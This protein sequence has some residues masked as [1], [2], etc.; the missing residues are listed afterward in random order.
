MSYKG[1][2]E[3]QKLRED[4]NHVWGQGW[5]TSA[6]Y[7][8]PYDAIWGKAGAL[9][10]DGWDFDITRE[11]QYARLTA[12]RQAQPTTPGTDYYDRFS[13]S[14]E[15]IEKDIW[16]LD[17]LFS[18]VNAKYY[19][20]LEAMKDTVMS[21][22]EEGNLKWFEGLSESEWPETWGVYREIAA[23]VEAYEEE[24]KVLTRE[25]VVSTLYN[26]KLPLAKY[27]VSNIYSTEALVRDFYLPNPIPGIQWPTA[28]EVNIPNTA[29]G[30]RNRDR[31]VSQQEGQKVLL[32][33]SWAWAAWSTNLYEEV[34]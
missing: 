12:T 20:E 23:G 4:I 31:N 11:G 18:E 30:W 27:N 1:T 34:T 19:G 33:E 24:Y 25:R 17:R 14:T 29:W 3:V 9:Q 28:P 26:D 2:I 21:V 13:I 10:L 16:T 15:T 6:E 8:G 32:T 7:Y 22:I 5:F